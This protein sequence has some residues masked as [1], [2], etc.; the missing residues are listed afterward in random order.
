MLIEP[1]EIDGRILVET[2]QRT[3]VRHLRSRRVRP[4]MG[5]P[6]DLGV[7]VPVLSALDKGAIHASPRE[8]GL[9]KLV[10]WA[11]ARS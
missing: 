9:L 7:T 1:S 11:A 3:P 6:A 5:I 10:D 4:G 2:W 8:N